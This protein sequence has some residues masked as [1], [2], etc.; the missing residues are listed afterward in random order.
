[1]GGHARAKSFVVGSKLRLAASP[2]RAG[3]HLA[4]RAPTTEDLVNVGNAYPEH[5]SRSMRSGPAIHR[6]NYSFT[7]I[8]RIE[9]CPL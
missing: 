9:H 7:Q 4:R 8:L 3:R 6:R 1:M 5:R 2:P